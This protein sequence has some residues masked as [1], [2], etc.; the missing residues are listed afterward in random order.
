[1][2]GCSGQAEAPQ[3]DNLTSKSAVFLELTFDAQVVGPRALSDAERK[4]SVV[5][6]LFYLSGELDKTHGG[7]GRFG[8]V[9]LSNVSVEPQDDDLELVRYHAVL[10]IAWPKDRAIPES[11]RIVVPLRVDREGMW[12]FNTKYA[13]T[14]GPTKYGAENMW[15]DFEPVATG[16]SFEPGEVVDTTASVAKSDQVTETKRPE[17][18]KFWQDGAFRMVLVHGSDASFGLDENDIGVRE[19][20]AFKQKLGEAF[21]G[22]EATSGET[23]THIW[24]RWQFKTKVPQ[25]GG[26]EG[27]LQIDTLLTSSL[28]SIGSDFDTVFSELSRDADVISYGGHSGLSKNILALADKATVAPQHYQVYF[29]DGCSTFAYL[30]STLSD[31]RIEANG[32]DLD[33]HGTK[34]LDVIVNAQ[35]VP[36]WSGAASQ[37]LVLSTLSDDEPHAYL[38]I[39]DAMSQSGMPLVAGE[40]DNPDMP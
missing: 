14:C 5:S 22:G 12:A 11:Y 3:E 20:I 9:E 39:L 7:H 15:Y 6:Q 29:L 34:F 26:G 16:C 37:W 2:G 19:Y 36:W 28:E 13:G 27:E 35:P 4:K 1:M 21:P 23:T 25:P 18:E 8:Y 40:E 10:P 38:D 24:D 32:A 30:D 31:R 17:H 33:P